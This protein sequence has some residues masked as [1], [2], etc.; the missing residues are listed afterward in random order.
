MDE[1]ESMMGMSEDENSVTVSVSN[2]DENGTT[3][4]ERVTD[5][6]SER[7]G[8]ATDLIIT[9]LEDDSA[10]DDDE[11]KSMTPA[12]GASAMSELVGVVNEGFIGEDATCEE[13]DSCQSQPIP[14]RYLQVEGFDGRKNDIVYCSPWRT[15]KVKKNCEFPEGTSSS[16]N[17]SDSQP[18]VPHLSAQSTPA[19]SDGESRAD[20]KLKVMLFFGG[21]IQVNYF[22]NLYIRNLVALA[23][24]RILFLLT[25]QDLP[26]MMEQHRDHRNY[27]QFNLEATAVQL[28]KQFPSHH[29]AVVR[30]SRIQ[31]LTFSCYDNFVHCNHTGAPEHVITHHSLQHL[32]L[33]LQNLSRR[34]TAELA[35]S[36]AEDGSPKKDQSKDVKESTS[37]AN[38]ERK[39]KCGNLNGGDEDA[40][41]SSTTVDESSTNSSAIGDSK[42]ESS[43]KG[44]R[45]C[46]ENSSVHRSSNHFTSSS[47]SSVKNLRLDR[48]EVSLVG[49]SKGCVVLNQLLYEFHYL[50]VKFKRM[51]EHLALRDIFK[52]GKLLIIQIICVQQTLTPDDLSMDDFLHCIKDMYWLDGG[53]NGGKNTWI[54]SRSLLE[55]LTR[56]QVRIHVHLTPYQLLDDRR[57]WIRKEEKLF[58]ELLKKFSAPIVRQIH[59]EN[60][61]ASL[62]QHLRIIGDFNVHSVSQQQLPS[63][64]QQ[65]EGEMSGIL[66]GSLDNSSESN[67]KPAASI[68]VEDGPS[69]H[70]LNNRE[71]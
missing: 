10:S 69:V 31:M 18:H 20:E 59:F 11:D 32:E 37:A 24:H 39:S 14:K 27:V 55:T 64:L 9:A 13:Q 62:Q 22:S 28:Q 8:S 63:L 16:S 21:D 56:L 43:P 40:I 15:S 45:Q 29:I 17:F 12:S 42:E 46:N 49:F 38:S 53:H 50:K 58:S 26:E 44:S 41:V 71:H 54:T 7:S 6:V 67:H 4:T 1:S 52:V 35:A 51:K 5:Q 3:V 66:I 19:K 34:I 61:P 36:E 2:V 23:L 30:P 25:F 57:P 47:S 33:L 68:V 65:A 48:A 70:H 60:E